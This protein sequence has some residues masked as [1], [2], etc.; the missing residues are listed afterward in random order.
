MFSPPRRTDTSEILSKIL[1]SLRCFFRIFCQNFIKPTNTVPATAEGEGERE[2]VDGHR[3]AEMFTER[4]FPAK[5]KRG[6]PFIRMYSLE[7]QYTKVSGLSLH[8][9]SFGGTLTKTTLGK[10]GFNLA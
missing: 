9:G 8:L 4:C 5:F 6:M 7:I 2:R 1:P 10:K 3:I